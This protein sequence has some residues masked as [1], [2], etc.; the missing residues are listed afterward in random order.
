LFKNDKTY[1]PLK[2]RQYFKNLLLIIS[3]FDCFKVKYI[4]WGAGE[5]C[6]VPFHI[7]LQFGTGFRANLFYDKS[8]D[9]AG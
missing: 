7:L 8:L 2:T 3:T 5:V 9:F 6:E 1:N 4:M